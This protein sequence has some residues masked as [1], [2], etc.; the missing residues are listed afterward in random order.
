MVILVV[1]IA[2]ILLEQKVTLSPM[3]KEGKK[4]FCRIVIPSKRDDIL[5]FNQYMKSNKAPSII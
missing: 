3:K 1:W 2:F 4:D 5:K